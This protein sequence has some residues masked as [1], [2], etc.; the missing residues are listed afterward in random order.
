[1]S[2]GFYLVGDAIVGHRSVGFFVVSIE[3]ELM[4]FTWLSYFKQVNGY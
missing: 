3:P 1:M 2:M 4:P